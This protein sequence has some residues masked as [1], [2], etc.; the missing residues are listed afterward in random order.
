MSDNLHWQLFAVFAP[1][2]L[3]SVGG[4]QSVIP[5]IEA[6]VVGAHGWITQEQFV[7]LFAISR[8]APGP[9]SLLSTLIGWQVAG[10]SGAVVATLSFFLPSCL[11]AYAASLAWSRRHG[12]AWRVA[13]ERGLAPI[14]T[15]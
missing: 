14:A 2:S 4:G 5:G 1:L 11:I 3:L 8:A 10:L 12:S 7:E 6:Q 9:G 13:I 15:G